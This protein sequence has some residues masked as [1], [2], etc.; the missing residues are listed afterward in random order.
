MALFTKIG[1][2][3][4]EVA[5]ETRYVASQLVERYF[6][7]HV[8]RSSAELAYYML[9]T[10]FPLVIFSNVLV[11][12]FHLSVEEIME[13]LSLLLPEQIVSL[14]T[15][16]IGYIT[17]LQPGTLVYAG[18]VLTVY[19]TSRAVNSLMLSIG[20]AYRQPRKGKLNFFFSVIVT[21][22][23]LLSM[24]LLLGLVLISENLLALA[25]RVLPIPFFLV[26]IWNWLRFT[27]MPVYLFCIITLFYKIAPAKWLRFLQAAPG[28]LFFVAVWSAI[29][30]FFSYYVSNLANYSVLYGSLGAVMILMLWFYMTGII[31]ILGGHLNHIVLLL[32]QE[33]KI[34][35]R[36]GE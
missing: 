21:V 9:F 18:S 16:Y 36:N 15:E 2:K 8:A 34:R 6:K 10:L 31:L 20:V 13:N 29:S 26:R 35:K 5:R 11:S 12:S 32:R 24:Y 19:F 14:I 3:L 30:Y 27:A 4:L 17:N 7:D 33:K 1:G 22:V 23:V 25:A 28:G